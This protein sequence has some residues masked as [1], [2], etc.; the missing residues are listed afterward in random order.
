MIISRYRWIVCP[1]LAVIVALTGCTSGHQSSD[2]VPWSKQLTAVQDTIAKEGDDLALHLVIAQPSLGFDS[3]NPTTMDLA[4]RFELIH[5]TKMPAETSFAVREVT[6]KDSAPQTTAM[7]KDGG[8]SELVDT[9]P[10]PRASIV[11]ISPREALYATLIEGQAHLGRQIGAADFLVRL[12]LDQQVPGSIGVP[13]AWSIVYF[14]KPMWLRVWVDAR[15][16]TIL[17]R[18]TEAPQ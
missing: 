6:F 17:S 5:A 18:S 14:G 3:T 16:G 13:A 12:F 7:L 2:A 4:V 9:V 10:L 1:M 15:T 11:Q 8:R